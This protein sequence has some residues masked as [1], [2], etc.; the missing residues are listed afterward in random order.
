MPPRLLSVL[1]AACLMTTSA[2]ADEATRPTAPQPP[3]AEP[4]ASAPAPE[5]PAPKPPD[6]GVPPD[7]AGFSGR[8]TGV[9]E[10][11]SDRQTSL[12]AKITRAEP[13]PG[14]SAAQ[15]QSLVG[16]VI[17]IA[18]GGSRQPDGKWTHDTAQLAWIAQLKPGQPLDLKVT[19][20][21]K[22]NRLRIAELPP[23]PQG[24]RP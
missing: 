3:A 5:T 21:P 10:T 6:G 8:I 1:K 12:K 14:S 11:I 19:F 23:P 24:T 13:A 9:V 2:S 18:A 22:F 20:S 16:L 15:P 7:A 4:S 17:T